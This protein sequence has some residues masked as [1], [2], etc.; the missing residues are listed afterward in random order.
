MDLKPLGDR[1]V[2]KPREREE[3]TKGGIYLPDTASK[4]RPIDGEVVAVGSGKR[5][6]S[7]E[8]LPLEVR[9]GNRVI[10]SE[11]SGSEVKISGEKYLI[12]RE[13]DVLALYEENK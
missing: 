9:T 13:S 4:E 8:R 7:G 6:K 11:Y 5:G 2:V 3:K 1:I 10:F 12:I